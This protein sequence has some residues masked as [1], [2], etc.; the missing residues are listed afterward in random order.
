MKEARRYK[1]FLHEGAVK[2][3]V[4]ADKR[5]KILLLVQCGLP[6]LLWAALLFADKQ[7]KGEGEV[8]AKGRYR[9]THTCCMCQPG[10]FF[11]EAVQAFSGLSSFFFKFF[12]VH[13]CGK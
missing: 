11:A 1:A 6:V 2:V 9:L 12:Y 8:G 13:Y 3:L 7:G 4:R 10:C 5:H